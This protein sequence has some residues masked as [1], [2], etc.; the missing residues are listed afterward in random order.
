MKWNKIEAGH[1]ESSDGKYKIKREPG[2]TDTWVLT[3]TER[4]E[5]F[6]E[7]FIHWSLKGCKVEALKRI[8]KKGEKGIMELNLDKFISRYE[9]W[10]EDES[11]SENIRKEHGKVAEWLRELKEKTRWIPVSE[12]MPEP[13]KNGD[14]DYSD[15]LEVT[16]L[17]GKNK[18]AY[19]GEAY[20][21]FSENKWYAKR[22]AV[23]EVTAWKPLSEPYKAETE[24]T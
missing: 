15:W 21:C 19:V 20:Y 22:F 8:E 12:K 11:I 24:N 17:I 2:T 7:S 6:E 9:Y 5:S 23:G 1:Y 16:I 14:K 4:G 18:D 10:A 13:Q 3:E